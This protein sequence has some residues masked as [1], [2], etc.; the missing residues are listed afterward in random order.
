MTATTWK[1]SAG[2]AARIPVARAKNLT[3][4]LK[5]AKQLGYFVLGLDGGGDISL[6]DIELAQEPV[7]IVVGSEGKGLSRLVRETC[8]QIVSIPITSA[9]ESLNASMAVGIS[10]YEIAMRRQGAQR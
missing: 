5:E 7:I 8:D 9:T 1:T 6:Q 10:L 4:T 3:Q 2:A